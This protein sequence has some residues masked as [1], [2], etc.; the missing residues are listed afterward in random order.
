MKMSDKDLDKLFSSQL[1]DM[2]IEPSA[3]VWNN[4]KLEIDSERKDKKSYIPF[5]QIAA[6]VMVFGTAAFI[7]RPKTEKIVLHGNSFTASVTDAQRPLVITPQPASLDNIPVI[8]EPQQVSAPTNRY[9]KNENTR[10]VISVVNPSA[11]TAAIAP[12]VIAA[13]STDH[14]DNNMQQHTNAARVQLST[15][16]PIL[17]VVTDDPQ[18]KPAKALAI[19]NVPTLKDNAVAKKKKI[20]NLGDLLNVMIAKVDKRQ[21]KIIEFNDDDD[22]D[23][24]NPTHINLGLIQTRRD[25]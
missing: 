4:I 20:R 16:K 10:R 8:D 3:A 23:T 11:D 7:F 5:L 21:K 12:Q 13:G 1:A 19:A 14:N 17:A 6:A 22:D 2:E 15:P 25:N 18:Q 9:A 24:L